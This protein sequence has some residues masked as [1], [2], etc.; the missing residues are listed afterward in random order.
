MKI[1]SF[2]TKARRLFKKRAEKYDVSIDALDKEFHLPTGQ[3]GRVFGFMPRAKENHFLIE[4]KTPLK[5][6]MRVSG[7]VLNFWLNLDYNA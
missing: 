5:G 2:E 4:I 6:R 3:F 7:A 1:E